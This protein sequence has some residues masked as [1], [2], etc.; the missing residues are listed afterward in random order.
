MN[1]PH[2]AGSPRVVQNPLRCRRFPGVNM[3]HDPDVANPV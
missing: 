2:L 3:R 1:F